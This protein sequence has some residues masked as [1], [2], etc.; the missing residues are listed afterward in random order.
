M[1]QLNHAKSDPRPS[2]WKRGKIFSE[3][4]DRSNFISNAPT[5][6]DGVADAKMLAI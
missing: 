1:S 6:Y 2:R 3:L 4:G 5:K